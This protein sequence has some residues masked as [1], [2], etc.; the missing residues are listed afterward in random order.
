MTTPRT[1]RLPR[2]ARAEEWE[3]LKAPSPWQ[4]LVDRARAR[5]NS[6]TAEHGEWEDYELQDKDIL[7]E[8]GCKVR[9]MN[10][11]L[12]CVLYV[13]IDRVGSSGCIRNYAESV[14]KFL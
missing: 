3:D 10:A 9:T 7:W 2:V 1:M 11:S 6:Q 4:D 5:T 13:Y 14:G 12:P 8:I